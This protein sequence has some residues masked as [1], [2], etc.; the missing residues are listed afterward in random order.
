MAFDFSGA[1][2]VEVIVQDAPSLASQP[3]GSI[4]MLAIRA[5]RG[6][7][8]K[9]VKMST[10][11][12]LIDTFGKRNGDATVNDLLY[13]RILLKMG[14]T[15]WV[16]RIVHYTDITDKATIDGTAATFTLTVTTNT[17]VWNAKYI[18]VGYNG[19]KVTTAAAT[20]GTANKLDVTIDLPDSA[21]QVVIRDLSDAPLQAEIDA[22]NDAQDYIELDSFT[23]AIPVGEA[24]LAGGVQDMSL[25]VTNDYVGDAGAQTGVRVF[26]SVADSYRLLNIRPVP[27]INK[28][29][30]EYVTGRTARTTLLLG[31]PLGLSGAGHLDYVK[32]E[33]A[34]AATNYQANNELL[35]YCAGEVNITDPDNA[36]V[37]IDVPGNL[38]EFVMELKN[39]VLGNIGSSPAAL[40]IGTKQPG[41]I[42][43]RNNGVSFDLAAGNNKQ[44]FWDELYTLGVNVITNRRLPNSENTIAVLDGNATTKLDLTSLLSKKNIVSNVNWVSR[45]ALALLSRQKNKPNVPSTWKVTATVFEQQIINRLIGDEAM[46]AEQGEDWQLLG[47]QDITD[48]SDAVINDPNRVQF[49][50]YAIFFVYKPNGVLEKIRIGIVPATESSFNIVVSE[51]TS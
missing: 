3:Q 32:G 5:D 7:P 25:I 30:D 22:F 6:E 37:N 26:D 24:I 36:D 51:L 21:T 35:D 4:G 39:D 47:D 19:I 9:R 17:V 50:E 18:G 42:P 44:D 13:A 38:F 43:Y 15:L 33:G 34:Y 29:L 45:E 20:S 11:Q 14:I 31:F 48:I 41:E 23:N 46:A 12:A 40:Q 10:E 27:A 28:A 1:P 16:T 49:G 8:S 2:S